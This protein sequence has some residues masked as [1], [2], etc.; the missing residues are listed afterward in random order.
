MVA[1]TRTPLVLAVTALAL[2]ILQAMNV[3]AKD[4]QELRLWVPDD[5]PADHWAAPYIAWMY[6]THMKGFS[7][8]F[9][10]RFID[11]EWAIEILEADGFDVIGLIES[12]RNSASKRKPSEVHAET[13]DSKSLKL[14]RSLMYLKKKGCLSATQFRSEVLRIRDSAH[15]PPADSPK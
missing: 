13:G 14:L 6:Q 1:N 12:Q 10:P 5:V 15:L 2:F 9:M 3:L 4:N 8:N 11:T 7:C